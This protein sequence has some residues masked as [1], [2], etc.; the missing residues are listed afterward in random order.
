MRGY[1]GDGPA[2]DHEFASMEQQGIETFHDFIIL[3]Y[4]NYVL[5]KNIKIYETYNPGTVF[6]IFAYCCTLKK[7]MV[8]WEM[9]QLLPV[10]KKERE[11]IPPIKH[12]NVPVR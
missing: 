8:L 5:P 4:E 1:G 10:E 9:N 11:F 7:W 12:I 6:R 2:I 3:K